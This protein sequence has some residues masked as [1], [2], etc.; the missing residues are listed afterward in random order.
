M[1]CIQCNEGVTFDGLTTVSFE[2]KKGLRFLF[3]NVPV[4]VCLVCGEEYLSEEIQ[5][6]RTEITNRCLKMGISKC[7]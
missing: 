1:K 3:R 5:D 7:L 6:R 2:K 4:M